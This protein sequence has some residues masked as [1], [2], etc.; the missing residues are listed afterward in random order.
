MNCKKIITAL[1]TLCIIAGTPAVAYIADNDNNTAFADDNTVNVGNIFLDNKQPSVKATLNIDMSSIVWSSSDESVAVVDNSG[2]ITAKGKG[3]CLIYAVDSEKTY[4]IT[5]TSDYEPV[6]QE[7]FVIHSGDITLTDKVVSQQIKVEVPDGTEVKYSSTDEM[8]AVVSADG[9]ITA[10]GSGECMIYADIGN[11][12]YYFNITSSY[13][14]VSADFIDIGT[15]DLTAESSMQTIRISGIPQDSHITWSCSDENI[16]VVSK[17][18]VVSGIKEGSCVVYAETDGRKYG[19]NINVHFNLD[20][21]MQTFEVKKTGE[22]LV[23]S[24]KSMTD[25]VVFTSSDEAVA[26]VDSKGTI[27]AKGIGEA[28]IKADSTGGIIWIRVKV[29]GEEKAGLAGDA[30]EDGQVD[31]ADATAIV[32]HLGNPDEYGRSPQVKINAEIVNNGDG[33]TGSDA[34]LLQLIEAK[35]VRQSDLPVSKAQYDARLKEEMTDCLP[36]AEKS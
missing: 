1:M 9:V 33:V 19:M 8:V 11:I 17:G 27:T 22:T 10:K 3:E 4:V 14:G 25:D 31:I 21:I 28:V 7:V 15:L 23:L 5:V 36:V 13:T 12:R 26:V 16:A 18:G 32:Q 35:K 34:V 30:N 29:I 24:Y 20:D 2:N 6:E